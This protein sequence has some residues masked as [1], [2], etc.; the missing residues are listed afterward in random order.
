MSY[1]RTF[2]PG[3]PVYARRWAGVVTERLA[4]GMLRVL[5]TRPMRGFELDCHP[6]QLTLHPLLIDDADDANRLRDISLELVEVGAAWR[7]APALS[8]ERARLDA[9][10]AHLQRQ[11]AA[12]LK[13][14]APR[15]M[16]ST[17]TPTPSTARTP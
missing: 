2:Y 8:E 10:R 6:A 4:N 15:S 7:E 9:R 3:D 16:F 12:L 17:S 5:Q 13:I 11:R 14:P 1:E